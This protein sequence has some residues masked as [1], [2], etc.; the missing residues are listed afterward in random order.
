VP[1]NLSRPEKK[2]KSEQGKE[3]KRQAQKVTLMVLRLE[4]ESHSLHSED[5]QTPSSSRAPTYHFCL[6]FQYCVVCPRVLDGLKVQ[7][8]VIST[9]NQLRTQDSVMLGYVVCHLL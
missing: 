2:E 3:P 8:E 5:P 6:G 4:S 9:G 1:G 7:E